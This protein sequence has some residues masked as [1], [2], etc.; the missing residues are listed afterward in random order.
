MTFERFDP[1]PPERF[2]AAH[3]DIVLNGLRA[4]EP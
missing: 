1:I 2:L 3:L 4:R